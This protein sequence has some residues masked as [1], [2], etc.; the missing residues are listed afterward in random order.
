MKSNYEGNLIIIIPPYYPY[1]LLTSQHGIPY[2]AA[3]NIKLRPTVRHNFCNL[4]RRVFTKWWTLPALL[5]NFS[6]I[7]HPLGRHN[8]HP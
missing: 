6:F 8:S 2:K 5:S 1:L 4:P 3:G 7:A